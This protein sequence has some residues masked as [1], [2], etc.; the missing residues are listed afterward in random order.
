LTAG[1]SYFIEELAREVGKLA[2]L[3]TALSYIMT[4]LA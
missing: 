3:T 1:V 4:E 2:W